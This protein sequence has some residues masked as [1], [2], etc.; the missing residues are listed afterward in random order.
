MSP[1]V[2]AI[3]GL[4]GAGK[5]ALVKLLGVKLAPTIKKW[6]SDHNIPIHT[7][8]KVCV[9]YEPVDVWKSSGALTHFY[10]DIPHHA[11]EFQ[12]FV[13]ITRIQAIKRAVKE[14][15]DANVYILERSVFS[16]EYLFVEMLHNDG[17]LNETQM[18]MYKTWCRT[19]DELL[20]WK[21]DGFVY[22]APSLDE[23]I[24]RIKA[25]ARNGEDVSRDYQKSLLDQHEKV[26]GNKTGI[27]T[28]ANVDYPVHA[29]R[30]DEDFRLENGGHV[31]IV[32]GV[33][34]FIIKLMLGNDAE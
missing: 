25:R 17:T 5:T 28:I 24:A 9:I 21:P 15:P 22:L 13:Y 18:K 19:Y 33:A 8:L 6:F 4:I 32:N 7:P 11:Y 12:T 27:A 23:T 16:D 3:D 14:Y 26:F 31:E 29:I 34:D 1:I 10:E 2:I 20:P 30:S